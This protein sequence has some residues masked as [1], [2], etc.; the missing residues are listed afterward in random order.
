VI[1]LHGAIT[2]EMYF[3]FRRVPVPRHKKQRTH[4]I[5]EKRTQNGKTRYMLRRVVSHIGGGRRW[6]GCY[7]RL[8][9]TEK[10]NGLE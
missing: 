10:K 2:N 1:D 5:T 9:L 6:M 3:I 7:V 8:F 4:E